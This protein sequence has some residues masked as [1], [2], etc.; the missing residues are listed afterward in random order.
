V[1]RSISALQAAWLLIR[2]RFRQQ[3]NMIVSLS[4]HRIGSPERKATSRTSP[5]MWLLTVF[6]VLTMF[7]SL[8]MVSHQM[9][10]N[11][12]TALGS[13]RVPDTRNAANRAGA[14]ARP[15]SQPSLRRIAPAPGSLLAPG[16]LQG[17]TFA[18][19]LLLIAALL[20]AVAGRDITRPDWD[21]EWLVTLPLPRSTLLSSMLIERAVT[22]YSGF[23]MLGSFLSVLAWTCGYRWTA[24]LLGLGLTFVLLLLA[25]TAQTLIDTGLRLSLSPAKLR[26]LHAGISIV[27]V[28]AILFAM[29]MTVADNV[30]VFGWASALPDWTTWLPTGL[31]VWA[32]AAV[33]IG[34]AALWSVIMIAEILLLVAVGFVLLQRQMRYGVVA[35]GPREAVGRR[36]AAERAAPGSRRDGRSLLSAVQRRELRLLGRD[37]TFM[38]QTLVLPA[39][40]VGAQ[41]LLNPGMTSFAS[42]VQH[43][44]LWAMFAFLLAVNTLMFSAFQTLNAEGQA[45]WILYCVPRSL[46]SVLW[47]KA[48]LWAAVSTVYPLVMFAIM[49]VLD[50]NISLQFIGSAAIVLLGVPIFAVI[51]TALG[52]FACDPL[53]QDIQRRIRPTYMYLFMILCSLYV[54]AIFA[55][56]I[57]HRATLAILTALVALALWQKAR[58]QFPYLLDPS[59]SPPQRVSVADGLIAAL[60]FFVLQGIV[61][62]LHVTIS[63]PA[64]VTGNMV[65]IA[66]CIA[67]A[68]TFGVMRLVY[69]RAR[70]AGVP[71]ILDAGVSRAVFWG[72]AGGVAASLAGLAYIQIV[73]A[74]DLFP[75]IRNASQFPDRGMAIWLAVLA[76][77]AAPVFEEFIFRGLIFGGLR[78]SLGLPTATIASAA[79]FA[80]VHPPVSVVPVFVLGVCAALIYDRTKMLAAP[81]IVHAIYNAVLVGSHWN[82]AP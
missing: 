41:I 23:L 61:L 12:E 7:G 58:D 66:F 45:L 79:I 70:T 78:R 9:I 17:A 22:N 21:L 69:W 55:S 24:P 76:I 64:T 48:K 40:M 73:L 5:T 80:I 71:R 53:A 56:S 29:S 74:L 39:I 62:M 18:A 19:S 82:V 1:T 43:P 44:S 72:A 2:L 54:Y 32:L 31:A 68:V 10:A 6:V 52:V 60:L 33:D 4:R 77:G 57:W 67:G 49:I 51:A 37:R 65:W 46:E 38:V 27:A 13:I 81:M 3:L 20:T 11:M 42:P 50:R 75:A 59:A 26:N 28:L 34:S 47:Q 25:A 35:A 63:R 16:V 36:P 30:F 15:S 8:V 14:P